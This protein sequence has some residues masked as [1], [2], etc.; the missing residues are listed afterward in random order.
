MVGSRGVVIVNPFPFRTRRNDSSDLSFRGRHGFQ[1]ARVVPRG[2]FRLAPAYLFLTVP[3]EHRAGQLGEPAR[4]R[5]QRRQVLPGLLAEELGPTTTLPN[6][7]EAGVGQFTTSGVFS[8]PL[9][10]LL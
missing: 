9:P 2:R 4:R 10:S 7:K 1:G 3:F 6:T 5:S 8:H